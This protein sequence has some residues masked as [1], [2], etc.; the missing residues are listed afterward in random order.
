RARQIGQRRR[1]ADHEGGFQRLAALARQVPMLPAVIARRDEHAHA[2]GR[3]H[4]AAVVADVDPAALGVL[5]DPVGG[6]GVGADVEAGCG[7]RA[8]ESANAAVLQGRAALVPLVVP[9][10][11][12]EPAWRRRF[13]LRLLPALAQ[14][15][16]LAAEP[17]RIV[18]RRTRIDADRHTALQLVAL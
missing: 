11:P 10:A 16:D 17:D 7:E 2:V 4:L 18:F 6:G 5:G 3:L 15:L 1:P 8:R 13:G 9:L 12:V 14:L